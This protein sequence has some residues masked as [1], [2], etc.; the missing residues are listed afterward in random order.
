[1]SLIKNSIVPTL[2]RGKAVRQQVASM[3]QGGIEDLSTPNIS[4]HYVTS[5]LLATEN[6]TSINLINPQTIL[7]YAESCQ[8]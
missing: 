8:L 7:K 3:Q 1:M 6:I 5:R 2:R 4:F